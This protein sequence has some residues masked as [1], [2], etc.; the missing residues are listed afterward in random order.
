MYKLY[1][2]SDKKNKAFDRIYVQIF[3]I[4]YCLS[5]ILISL[6]YK[7]LIQ[8]IL[9]AEINNDIEKCQRMTSVENL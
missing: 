8:T 2:F 6:S 7:A 5:V 4:S 1:N 9:F 3:P